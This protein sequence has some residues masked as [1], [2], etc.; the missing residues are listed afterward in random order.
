MFDTLLTTDLHFT[1]KDSDSYRFSVFDTIHGILDI[2]PDIDSLFIL[3]DLTTFKDGHPAKL[4][5]LVV[6]GMVQLAKRV[7]VH[8]IKGNHD[9]LVDPSLPFF[10][11]LDEIEGIHFYSVPGVVNLEW[12]SVYVVPHSRTKLEDREDIN[13]ELLR[14]C[15]SV[16]MHETFG[17][18]KSSNGMVMEGTPTSFLDGR[19]KRLCFS[20]DIHVPQRVRDVVYVGTP[21]PVNYGD[22]FKPRMVLFDSGTSDYKSLAVEAIRKEALVTN[23]GGVVDDLR[24]LDLVEGDM[25]KLRV[26]VPTNKH[27]DWVRERAE[28]VKELKDCGVVLG[29]ISVT[30]SLKRVALTDIPK[31]TVLSYSTHGVLERFAELNGLA[32]SFVTAGQVLLDENRKINS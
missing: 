26:R 2:H 29:G 21:Y 19:I 6:T 11:F 5:S 4:V 3:G 32:P 13:W 18:S 12:G 31:P 23:V 1:D 17:G 9:Y 27:D 28:V 15:E 20:G 22:D 14:Q 7:Q 10:G 8:I 25:V 16:F 30:S 24:A